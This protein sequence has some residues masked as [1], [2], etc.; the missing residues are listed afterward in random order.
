M[1]LLC[2]NSGYW[3]THNFLAHVSL[4]IA[5]TNIQNLSYAYMCQ[6]RYNAQIDK[7]LNVCVF[8]HIFFHIMLESLITSS[9]LMLT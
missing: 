1:L 6:N 3:N 4:S 5:N 8:S 9:L 7:F 2:E